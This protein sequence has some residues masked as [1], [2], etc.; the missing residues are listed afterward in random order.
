[1]QSQ[2]QY[3]RALSG[4]F[5]FLGWDRQDLL[6]LCAALRSQGAE[7]P[8]HQAHPITK[9]E[10]LQLLRRA[11][12]PW[13][14]L[15]LLIAWKSASR[16]GEVSLLTR[17]HLIK[18]SPEE[19]VIGWGTLPKGKRGQPFYPSMFTVIVGDLTREIARLAT[20]L[21]PSSE[22]PF[23]PL[24]TLELDNWTRKLP[25][26]LNK[27]TGHSFKHGAATHVVNRVVN[28]KLNLDPR[29]LSLLLKHKLAAD[30]ISTSTLRY[31]SLG[32]SLAKWLG[33]QRVTNLL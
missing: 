27:I 23:C 10:L 13:L 9:E 25:P 5:K 2:L 32:V 12:N 28:E 18:I 33:T 15:A 3:A 24:G 16:W 8:L 6:T 22:S 14:Y 31:P 21:P 11:K 4:T 26:P 1:M 7:V 17:R 30:L 29:D 19:V 20:L